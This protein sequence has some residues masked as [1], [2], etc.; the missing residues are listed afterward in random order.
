M[1]IYAFWKDLKQLWKSKKIAHWWYQVRINKLEVCPLWAF[2]DFQEQITFSTCSSLSER[3]SF[4]SAWRSFSMPFNLI[5]SSSFA[6]SSS[7]VFSNSCC[8]ASSS[9]CKFSIR[10]SLLATYIYAK[11]LNFTTR[12]ATQWIK[13][14]F[15]GTV[16]S[17][18][19]RKGGNFSEIQMEKT[20]NKTQKVI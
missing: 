3:N 9:D 2:N 17:T 13:A 6:P 15:H 19:T 12:K 11:I 14:F 7:T 18:I 5:R 10:P 20:L 4:S 8:V 16:K 1:A